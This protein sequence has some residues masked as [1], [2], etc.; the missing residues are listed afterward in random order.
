V[1]KHVPHT[2]S[3]DATAVETELADYV[4][5]LASYMQRYHERDDGALLWELFAEDY[6]HQ[7]MEIEEWLK[8]RHEMEF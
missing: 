4:E 2:R 1:P 7:A 6:P 3:G 8:L 5:M